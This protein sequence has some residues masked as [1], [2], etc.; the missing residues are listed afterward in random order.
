M[1]ECRFQTLNI[2]GRRENEKKKK[3]RGER[4]HW[5]ETKPTGNGSEMSDLYRKTSGKGNITIIIV[6]ESF[7]RFI[8]LLTITYHFLRNPEFRFA[9][10][11]SES[12][13]RCHFAFSFRRGVIIVVIIKIEIIA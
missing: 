4:L 1:I 6:R 5:D 10:N 11:D 3:Q 8:I 2:E 12:V 13:L 9:L 7:I